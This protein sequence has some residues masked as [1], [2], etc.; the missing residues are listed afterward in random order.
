LTFKVPDAFLLI[1]MF[2]CP[3]IRYYTT[4]A[5]KGNTFRQEFTAFSQK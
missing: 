4:S 3:Q 5:A 2:Y 1:Y